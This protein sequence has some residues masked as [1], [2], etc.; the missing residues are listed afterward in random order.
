MI[1]RVSTLSTNTVTQT[2]RYVILLYVE[3]INTI[4][5]SYILNVRSRI[6]FYIRAHVYNKNVDARIIQAHNWERLGTSQGTRNI[7]LRSVC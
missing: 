1:R 3:K 7:K 5:V 6:S 4:S 2:N